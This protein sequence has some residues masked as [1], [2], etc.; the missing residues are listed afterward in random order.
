MAPAVINA[1]PAWQIVIAA[2]R[3]KQEQFMGPAMRWRFSDVQIELATPSAKLRRQRLA[4]PNRISSLLARN[5]T[6]RA[7]PKSP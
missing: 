5:A 1:I 7:A 4:W 3:T 2:S 6:E